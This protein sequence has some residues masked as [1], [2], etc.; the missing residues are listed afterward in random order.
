MRSDPAEWH[1]EFERVVLC[2]D[3]LKVGADALKVQ[4]GE[5]EE[6]AGQ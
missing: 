4:M 6:H 1:R 2:H 5:N 3:G